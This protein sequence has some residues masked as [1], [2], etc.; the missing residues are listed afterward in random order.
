MTITTTRTDCERSF[1]A[2]KLPNARLEGF[3]KRFAQPGNWIVY[4][5]AD[6]HHVGRVICSVVCEGKTYVEIAQASIDFGSAFVRWIDPVWVKECRK[7]PP[8]TVFEFFSGDWG[9]PEEIH[10]KLAYGVSDLKD[11][12]SE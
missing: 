7:S 6:F 9:S 1:T 10:A 11:Q 8:K 4:E 3:G 2:V 5:N 12:M